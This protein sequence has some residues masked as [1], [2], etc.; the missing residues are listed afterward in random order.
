MIKYLANQVWANDDTQV[1]IT[2][3]ATSYDNT[4]I[5]YRYE[6]K[7]KQY[8]MPSETFATTFPTAVGATVV[9]VAEAA[10]VA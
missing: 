4:Y 8:E 6:D 9:E 2:T 3:V 10:A 5:R 1:T 7:N